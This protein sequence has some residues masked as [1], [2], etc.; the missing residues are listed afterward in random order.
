[1]IEDVNSLFAVIFC[2]FF[3]GISEEVYFGGILYPVLKENFPFVVSFLIAGVLFGLGH[4]SSAYQGSDAWLIVFQVINVIM[5]GAVGSLLLH[6][7]KS[8]IPLAIWHF[9]FDFVNHISKV[10]GVGLIVSV[11]LQEVIMLGYLGYLIFLFVKKKKAVS[12]EAIS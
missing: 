11:S 6:L 8:L 7:G 3:I 10:N 12:I 1:M 2:A 4:I 5:F 9:L